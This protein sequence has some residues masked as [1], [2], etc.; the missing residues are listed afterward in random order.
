MSVWNLSHHDI[1]P[2]KAQGGLYPKFNT[3]WVVS[4]PSGIL[5]VILMVAAAS[6]PT[7]LA[8]G[9]PLEN[10]SPYFLISVPWWHLFLTG[11]GWTLS[12]TSQ[13]PL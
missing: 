7:F 3:P 1:L 9:R 8:T 6:V 5:T 10:E 11:W 12:G 4:L 2:V 13:G